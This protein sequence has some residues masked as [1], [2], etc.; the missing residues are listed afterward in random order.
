MKADRQA[1]GEL[2][3]FRAFA[4]ACPLP[5]KPESIAKRD[6]PEPDILCTVDGQGEV[7][8]ELT[9]VVDPGL[10]RHF[11]SGLDLK[12]QLYDLYRQLPPAEQEKIHG[13]SVY[14]EF[15]QQPS[16]RARE[17]L[18]P[19]ILH[20]V[21]RQPADF[22]GNL[23]IPASSQPVVR[24]VRIWP[25]PQLI[26]FDVRSRGGEH[27]P[28]IAAMESKLWKDFGREPPVELL[29][30]SSIQVLDLPSERWFGDLDDMLNERL[31]P[32]PFR[33]VWVFNYASKTIA[34]IRPAL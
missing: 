26:L 31:E 16:A 30:Y 11:Y 13:R 32:S 2:T 18:L 12:R 23:V 4:Q 21:A 33:R 5:I 20:W 8:F 25:A 15:H 17:R 6:P 3:V 29:A 10:A 28:T 34:Y 19:E 9:E 24:Q 1:P 27:R 22:E 14:V 7:G